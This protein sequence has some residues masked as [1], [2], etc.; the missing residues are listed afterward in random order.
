MLAKILEDNIERSDSLG[1]WV[2]PPLIDYSYWDIRYTLPRL[3]SDLVELIDYI[4]KKYLINKDKLNQAEILS[5]YFFLKD[6]LI[7][8]SETEQA[9]L[10]NRNN[11]KSKYKPS[12]R[13]KDFTGVL[14]L[15]RLSGGCP[16]KAKEIKEMKYSEVFETLL[17]QVIESEGSYDS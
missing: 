15:N 6:E 2:S 13:S 14:E 17:A 9:H 7:K 3:L 8:I 1:G 12:A 4:C 11:V 16:I 10:T 5:F